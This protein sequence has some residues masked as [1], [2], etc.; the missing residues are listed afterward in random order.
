MKKTL[1]N[2]VYKI[3]LIGKWKKESDTY[4]T[5]YPPGHYANPFPSIPEVERYKSKIDQINK[6]NEGLDLKIK[7]QF[8]L[9]KLLANY[10]SHLP[11]YRAK[12]E[13]N[14]YY[15]ENP[16]FSFCD[17][18]TLFSIINHFKPHQIIEIG[19]GFSSAL[20]LD[21][22]DKLKLDTITTFIEP[23]PLRLNQLLSPTD[24]AKNRVIIDFI[25]NVDSNIFENLRD[26]DLLFI[27]SSHILKTG[28]DLFFELFSILPKLKSGVIIHF[29]DIFY[30]FDYPMNW[31]K[32]QKAYNESYFVKAFL[33]FNQQYEILLMNSLLQHEQRQW[34][35]NN[36]PL[37]LESV[38]SSLYIRK[39]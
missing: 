4:R 29:H 35:E 6:E 37:L 26:G 5:Y 2:I 18:I 9:L 15:Y 38:G 19:S 8:E 25:Q 22:V 7:Q 34:I 30:D 33:M 24:I 36:M 14:R 21:T 17:G 12:S 10:Y 23:Y 13:Q 39:L 16:M 27:D 31:V 28:S 3:P 20:I 11:F 32:S 1:K